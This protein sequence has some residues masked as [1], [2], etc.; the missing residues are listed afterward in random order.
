M[1]SPFFQYRN[2][3]NLRGTLLNGEAQMQIVQVRIVRPDAITENLEG[4]HVSY[5]KGTYETCDDFLHIGSLMGDEGGGIYLFVWDERQAVQDFI[6]DDPFYQAGIAEYE[7]TPYLIR[8][9]RL[10]QI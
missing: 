9:S 3:A 6:N 10:Q 1:F 4:R 2:M 8:H 5:V 7:I